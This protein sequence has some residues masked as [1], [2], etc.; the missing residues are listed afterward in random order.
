MSRLEKFR[1]NYQN[2]LDGL[3]KSYQDDFNRLIKNGRKDEAVFCKIKETSAKTMIYGIFKS[4]INICIDHRD[5]HKEMK[6]VHKDIWEKW[7][8]KVVLDSNYEKNLYKIFIH[9]W[10]T[11]IMDESRLKKEKEYNN[12]FAFIK[13]KSKLDLI[14]ECRA[15]FIEM[16]KSDFEYDDSWEE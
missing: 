2:Y 11:E 7:G 5:N 3:V 13:E 9:M 15:K 10:M 4:S 12:C 16:I 1:K 14:K 8:E 6:Q